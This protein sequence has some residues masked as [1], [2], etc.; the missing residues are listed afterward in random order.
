MT[1]FRVFRSRVLAL[2]TKRHREALLSEEIQ[3]HL[4]LLTDEYIR[5]GMSVADARAAA[6][7]EFGGVEQ[8]KE[9]YR[10]QR[11]WPLVET[12][13]RDLRYAVRSFRRRPGFVIAVVLSL[14]L[15]IGLNSAIFTVLNAVILRSLPVRNPWEL[16]LALPQ[17]DPATS[18]S[19]LQF[20]YP[21]F[22]QLRRVAPAT[23]TLSAMSRVA[24]M[25]SMVRGE[26][27]TIAVQLVSGGFFSMLGVAPV[28]GRMLGDGDNQHVGGHA[29]AVISHAYWQ[30]A[31]AGDPDVVG[32]GLTLNGTWFT[33]VGVSAPGFAGVWLESPVDVWVPLVMQGDVRYAQNF[34]NDDADPG[35]PFIPQEGIRWLDVVGRQTMPKAAGI[36]PALEAAFAATVA[37]QAERI[38]DPNRRARRLRQRLILEPFGEGFSNL[39]TRFATP[40]FA[41]FA[42]AALI[43]LIACANTV[44]LMLARA[45]TMQRE[46]AI[47]LSI[48][49]SRGR[50]IRQLLTE[51]LLL[52]AIATAVGLLFAGWAGELLVRQATGA[53]GPAP[54]AVAVDGP[55]IAFT[56][57][58]AVVTVLLFGLAPAFRTTSLQVGA[59]LRVSAAG[60]STVPPRLQKILVAAQVAL[61]L[62]LL[63]GAGLFIRTL[64]NYAR[65]S[66]GFSH[67]QVLS[68]RLDPQAAG[69]SPARLS[70]LYRDLVARVESIPGVSSASVAECALAIG[71]QN[72][73]GVTVEG[74]QPATDERVNAQENR[75]SL[76]YFAT[77]G[78]RLVEG[79][80]FDSR[81]R[82]DTTK[83]AIVNRAMAERYFRNGTAVGRH[84]GYGRLDTEVVGVVEDARVNRVQE[85]ARPM[86]FFPMAQEITAARTLDVR[87]IGDPRSIAADVRRAVVEVDKAL[88]IGSV[89]LLSDQVAGGLRQERLIAGLTSLFGILALGLASVGL[90]GVMSYAVSRRTT[91]FGIRMALG[92]Q[93]SRVLR[94]VFRESLTVV[95]Y[96]LAAGIPA[97]LIVS[98]LL[99]SLLFGVSPND[100]TTVFIAALL[101]A[102]VAAV[103]TLLPAWRASRVDPMVA[104]RCE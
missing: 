23:D 25:Y 21:V 29:V 76:N 68:V 64:Q 70:A 17:D 90:F 43:L 91:E 88:P 65:I 57:T 67:E 97:T 46:V 103:A 42:M 92:A 13:F 56:V 47:R 54:F 32:R 82:E 30:R 61:S 104:L 80:H 7:R 60:G 59:A 100:P 50:L 27:Q 19:A 83:V 85:P 77:T 24:R 93:Q 6:R 101:L 94:S 73:S 36:A 8:I 66:L 34:S 41:L 15:G 69:Y 26:S 37:A 22:D 40:L 55:V 38:D 18:R 14:S 75:I 89:T 28:R 1:P 33:I 52:G 5:G 74:Y 62:V 98:S 9:T 99:S 10:D 4:D 45:A 31:F 72:I 95:A 12:T 44:N 86:A 79:R 2:F 87:A 71:C 20:S 81:D 35:K 16:F 3:A 63:A 39:R 11:G 96:G 78:M 102:A 53:T 84:F 48:G 51:S 58:A 49:A